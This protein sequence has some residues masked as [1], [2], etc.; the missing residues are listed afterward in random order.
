MNE[1]GRSIILGM[2]FGDGYVGL[3]PNR[4]TAL[5]TIKHCEKQRP[6]A[7]YKARL[8]T[9]ILGGKC[10]PVRSIDNSGY[11]GCVFS[12]THK[13]LRN[14]RHWL[15]TSG[16]KVLSPYIKWLTP[17]GLAI[18]YMDDG[19][20]GRKFRR[21]KIHAVDLYINCQTDIEEAK[22]ICFEIEKRFG[23]VFR[24]NKN[25]NNFRIICGTR[26][27]RKF[28]RI[29]APFMHGSMMY[30]IAIPEEPTSAR[31]LNGVMI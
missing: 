12:K 9:N 6:Y 14:L 26:E 10:P 3:N 27:A 31:P 7:E 8:I 4:D 2:V 23:I 20:L 24:P 22:R 28:A 17:E 15:Y 29:V 13:Y 25:H 16:K 21:G 30:K 18:W 19:G 1:D 5:I 11:P